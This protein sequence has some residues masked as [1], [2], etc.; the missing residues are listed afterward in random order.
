MII[1]RRS[2]IYK[3]LKYIILIH[4]VEIRIVQWC[5]VT[6]YIKYTQRKMQVVHENKL[7]K[8]S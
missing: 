8:L 7:T 3:Y 6:L 1:Q 4:H 2:Y 5:V